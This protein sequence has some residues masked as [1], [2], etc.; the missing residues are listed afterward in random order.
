MLKLNK[1]LI[2]SCDHSCRTI[3][4]DD[5]Y[6]QNVVLSFE[7]SSNGQNHSSSDSHHPTKKIPSKIYRSPQLGESPY[8]SMQ[9]AL[10]FSA[11]LKKGYFLRN[12]IKTLATIP[13]H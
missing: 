1:N 5:Q 3:L 2:L 8:P 4:I 7:K 6:V 10:K 11:C 13:H 12:Y 9:T